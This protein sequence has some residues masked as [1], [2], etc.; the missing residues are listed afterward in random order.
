MYIYYNLFSFVSK[1]FVKIINNEDQFDNLMLS[2]QIAV[3]STLPCLLFARR[4][5]FWKIDS[6]PVSRQENAYVVEISLKVR[7]YSLRRP[8]GNLPTFSSR[9]VFLNYFLLNDPLK[10]KYLD[11]G[12]T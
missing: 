5:S 9:I 11:R 3:H 10:R 6:R 8:S 4:I 12:N 7:D 1:H 2:F